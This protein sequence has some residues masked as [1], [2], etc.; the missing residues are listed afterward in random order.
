MALKPNARTC[1]IREQEIEDLPS[2]LT[3]RVETS[4]AG[5][6]LVLRGRALPGYQR[7]IFFD[8]EGR[9]IGVGPPLQKLHM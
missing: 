8:A 7:E 6:R 9:A 1:F 5:T 3:L 2:G 4:A